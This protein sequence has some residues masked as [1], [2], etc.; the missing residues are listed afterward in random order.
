MKSIAF[1]GRGGQGIVFAASVLAETLF[2]KGLYVAQLQ[3][4]GAEVRGGSVLAYV[5]YDEKHVDNPFIE[6]FDIT[7]L[8]HEAGVTRW[9]S[10]LK[11]SS[12]VVVNKDLVQTRYGKKVITVP[13]T[14]T[15]SEENLQGKENICSLGLIKGLGLV[16][17]NDEDMIEILK[18]YRD[19]EQNIRA[20]NIGLK[21][22]E[23]IRR[24][25]V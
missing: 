25:T 13:I 24:N 15:L 5:V 18:K 6:S 11:N 23:R 2:R 4:Y 21:L 14:G 17:Y 8:L 22:G 9:A 19:W 7:I 16:N 3:S 10:I 12:I 20:Y 1:L